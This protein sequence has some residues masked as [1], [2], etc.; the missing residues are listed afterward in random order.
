MP[1]FDDEEDMPDVPDAL[2]IPEMHDEPEL[3]EYRL[4]DWVT[5][6]AAAS[7]LY[8]LAEPGTLQLLL[9]ME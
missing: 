1:L 2:E 4:A 9:P 7:T 8:E 3:I 6:A 5:R